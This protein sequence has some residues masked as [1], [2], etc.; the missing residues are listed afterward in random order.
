MSQPGV[1]R[2]LALASSLVVVCALC[3]A[4]AAIATIAEPDREQASPVGASEPTARFVAAQRAHDSAQYLEAASAWYGIVQEPNLGHPQERVI[5]EYQLPLALTRLGLIHASTAW[6]RVVTEDH[7]HPMRL[8]AL[9]QLGRIANTLASP[10]PLLSE[11]SWSGL[12]DLDR[13]RHLGGNESAELSYWIGRGLYAAGNFAEAAR[14]FAQVEPAHD[15]F[16]EA[17]LFECACHVR[18]HHA[19]PALSSLW[20]GIQAITAGDS[21]ASASSRRHWLDLY[22]LSAARIYYTSA[23]ALNAETNVPSLDAAR[24]SASVKYYNLIEPESEYFEA[25]TFELAWVYFMAGEYSFALGKIFTLDAPYYASIFRPEALMLKAVIYNANCNYDAATI[26]RA[27]FNERFVPIRDAV[28]QLLRQIKVNGSGSMLRV[29]D[30]LRH[31]PEAVG[32]VLEPILGAIYRE[33]VYLRGLS[34]AD[35]VETE[36]D[37]FTELPEQF[38]HSA[39]GEALRR[40]LDIAR[41]DAASR[42][43][44]WLREYLQRRVDEIDALVRTGEIMLLNYWGTQRNLLDVKLKTGQVGRAES[45]D[46]GRVQGDEE[47]VLWPFDGEY[48]RDELGTYRQTILSTCG[49]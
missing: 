31:H 41:S 47:H 20:R 11:F 23:V 35:A 27:R 45:S 29:V 36:I 39:L 25:A 22:H 18:R 42:A 5:A 46:W 48:W 38:R 34:S 9:G 24:I 30:G 26:V 2:L 32:P 6:F 14:A 43:D 28:K 10:D 13:L 16:A 15:H 17:R 21:H 44:A 37:H 7:E 8:A 33:R 12:R 1:S 3:P 49:R 19:V 40:G 4:R